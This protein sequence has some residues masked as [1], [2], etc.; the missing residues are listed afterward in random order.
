VHAHALAFRLGDF[1]A[2]YILEQ[3]HE[4]GDLGAGRFQFSSENAN[5]VS[6]A[7]PLDRPR[8]LAHG[9]IPADGRT[10]AAPALVAQRPLRP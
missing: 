8:P 2:M 7:T 3:I 4:R 5:S 1:L 6:T 10:A 9:F